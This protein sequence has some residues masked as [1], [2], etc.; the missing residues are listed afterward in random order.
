MISILSILNPYIMSILNIINKMG[1]V[2]IWSIALVYK[3]AI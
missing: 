2:T 1:A 3:M